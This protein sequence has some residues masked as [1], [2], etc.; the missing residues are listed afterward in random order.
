MQELTSVLEQSIPGRL[1]C[2]HNCLNTENKP[3]TYWFH[4]NKYHILLHS[5]DSREDKSMKRRRA[6]NLLTM[7]CLLQQHYHRIS[8]CSIFFITT[9][10]WD[11]IYCIA[12]RSHCSQGQHINSYFLN[13]VDFVFLRTKH[14]STRLLTLRDLNAL[15]KG[16]EYL[17]QCG[18]IYIPWPSYELCYHMHLHCRKLQGEAAGKGA[19]TQ[20]KEIT[21]SW[22]QA[23]G[24]FGARAQAPSPDL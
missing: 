14:M 12:A 9:T 4:H 16:H 7:R 11:R 13:W 3:L 20:R 19:R 2:T 15:H 1:V 6:G 10:R 18:S 23:K 24:R 21:F 17:W 5:F 8:N 22:Q